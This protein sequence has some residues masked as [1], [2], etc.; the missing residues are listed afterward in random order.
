MGLYRVLIA[1]SAGA[2]ILGLLLLFKKL[3]DLDNS[4]KHLYILAVVN[5]ISMLTFLFN[6]G[7]L[8]DSVWKE[9]VIF[10]DSAVLVLNL[11]MGYFVYQ[12]WIK[13]EL[14]FPK[15]IMKLFLVSFLSICLIVIMYYSTSG[16][17]AILDKSNSA[18]IGIYGLSILLFF[19]GSL[20]PAAR[21]LKS[22]FKDKVKIPQVLLLILL[23]G[24]N[25]TAGLIFF[26]LEIPNKQ[27]GIIINIIF[28]LLFAYTIGYYFLSEYFEG[29]R[30]IKAIQSNS[31]SSFSWE[32]MRQ[33]LT[34][35]GEL[36]DY[37]KIYYPDIIKEVDV[38][39]L[40]ELEKIH[41][42]LKKLNIKAKD[43]ADAM[44]VSVK[45][46]EMNRYRINVKLKSL[47]DK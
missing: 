10:L 40:S 22:S 17:G 42:V 34:Y 15:Q 3:K 11:T 36:K 41:L 32:S 35:W 14:L 16:A 6:F 43:I 19:F 25:N 33:H 29:K 9:A 2:L 5:V 1:V 4:K 38:L 23:N 13:P 30:Q 21:V 37:L 26:T 12:S 28:N 46:I 39:P 8:Y 18:F 7:N 44:N 27:V 31:T 45:A 24:L 47:K 20:V